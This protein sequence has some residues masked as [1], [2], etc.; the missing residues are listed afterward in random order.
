M[1]EIVLFFMSTATYILHIPEEMTYEMPQISQIREFMEQYRRNWKDYF[2]G[3]QNM[4]L[5]YSPKGKMSLR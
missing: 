3:F 4:V 1:I 2:A 5:S